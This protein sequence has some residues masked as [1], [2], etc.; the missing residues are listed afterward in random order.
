MIAALS[1]QEYKNGNILGDREI[2]HLMIALLMGGQHTS[3]STG[4]WILLHLADCPD[5][6]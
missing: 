6:V 5:I 4:A 1:V 2:A 3:A